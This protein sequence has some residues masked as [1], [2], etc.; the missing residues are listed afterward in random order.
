[1]AR[2]RGSRSGIR[3]PEPHYDAP[4]WKPRHNPWLVAITVTLATFM[5]VLDT[6]I[7]NVALPHMA[8]TLGASTE[9]ATW[10]LTSYL[11][12]SAIVLPISGWLM[13]RFGRKRFYMSC[14][15]LFT[16]SSVMCGLAAS[17]PML[18]FF[19]ILQGAGGGGLAPSEQ[20][21]LADA[22][23]ISKRG[24]AFALYGM[25][26]VVAPAVGPTLG[27]WI[28]DNFT[29][30][31]I[32]FI[33][34]P[35]GILSLFLTQRMVEDPPYLKA[36]MNR[37]G[38]VDTLGLGLIAIGVGCL[39]FVLDKGQEKDWFGDRMIVTFTLI[40]AFTLIAFVWWEW[41]HED[42]IVDIRLLKNRNFGTAV[43]LQ[44]VLGMVLFGSTVLIPQFV[45]VLLGYT[46]ERAGLVLSPGAVVLLCTMPIA[47]RLVS[48]HKLDPRLMVALGYAATAIGLYNLTRL[49]LGIS[50][51]EI[52]LMRAFQVIGLSFIFIPISTL[53]YVGVPR[54]K[55]NQIS[56]FSNF[57]RNI[58]GSAGTALLTTFLQR[59]EQ[60]HRQALGSHVLAGSPQY[61][62]F[63]E[64][65][66]AALMRL[67][68]DSDHAAQLAMG[69]AWQT[70]GRQAS[71]LSYQNAFWALSVIVALLVPLPFIMR[72][73]PPHGGPAPDE[74]A[75]H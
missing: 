73:P 30:H 43:F 21:I 53:N 39:E 74:A 51:G 35:V 25:A 13:Q 69:S 40:A 57:A 47:G 14:V 28:T 52:T 22:F 17:L 62:S 38:K 32:F 37:K 1:M 71:M 15:V 2:P 55:N 48:S 8:G 16:I 11:V 31:W 65:T 46:A 33:N 49:N 23:P 19:R 63:I 44:F 6:S 75:G 58:G 41:Q 7:A 20:A 50:Y 64:I 26:V 12:A 36:G 3:L 9:E 67:G 70:L 42:P 72:R 5:E 60:T 34:V 10:V 68:Q 59:T 45:Q 66:K 61:E 56:S 24:Q 54:D 27:G 18:I 29:W 4:N